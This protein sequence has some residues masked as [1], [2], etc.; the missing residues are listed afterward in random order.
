MESTSM[1][2]IMQRYNKLIGGGDDLAFLP[3]EYSMYLCLYPPVEIRLDLD[4]V[5][6]R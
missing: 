6:T 3:E 5:Q 4:C 1:T 2:Q